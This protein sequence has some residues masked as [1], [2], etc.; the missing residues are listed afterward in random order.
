MLRITST[1]SIKESNSAEPHYFSRAGDGIV[2][3]NIK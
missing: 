1:D 2:P 3:I